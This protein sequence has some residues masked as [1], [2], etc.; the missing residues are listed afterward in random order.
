[1]PT[2]DTIDRRTILRQKKRKGK[3]HTSKYINT[4]KATTF[5]D[6]SSS[7]LIVKISQPVSCNIAGTW[8]EVLLSVPPLVSSTATTAHTTYELEPFIKI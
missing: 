6:Q 2:F 8:Y 7:A 5:H 3:T 4:K 1:M